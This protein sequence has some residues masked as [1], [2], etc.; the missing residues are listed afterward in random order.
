MKLSEVASYLLSVRSYQAPRVL[1]EKLGQ[2]GYLK[3]FSRRW[4]QADESGYINV[5]S[6]PGVREEMQETID[7]DTEFKK[8]IAPVLNESFPA[9]WRSF[10]GESPDM[11]RVELT[12]LGAPNALSSGQPPSPVANVSAPTSLSPA[13]PGTRLNDA[14]IGDEVT[15]AEDGNTYT[16]RVQSKGTDGNYKLTFG[17]N[18]KPTRDTF[19]PDELKVT[20]KAPAVAKQ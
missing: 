12:E 1:H 13:S 15:V 5:S 11:R 9:S 4:I 2:E 6:N 3:A 20:A 17:G 16:A 10:I 14:S 18:T 7:A 19:K 8:E